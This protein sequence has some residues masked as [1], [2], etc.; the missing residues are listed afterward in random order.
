MNKYVLSIVML[1]LGI[2]L[3]GAGCSPT[4]P[5]GQ[6]ESNT[7]PNSGS[8]M[9]EEGD[10]VES[11]DDGEMMVKAD[12]VVEVSGKNFSFLP[13]VIT[14][15]KGQTVQINFTSEQGYHDWV[16]DEFDAATEQINAPGKNSVTFVADKA[17]EFEFYCSVGQHRQLG[18]V[19][20]LV[21][22]DDAMMESG[23]VMEKDGDSMMEN[24]SKG[25]VMSKEGSY[26]SYDVSKLSRAENG[27]V[28]LFFHA[29]WCPTCRSLDKKLN[30]ELSDFP[31]DLTVLKADYDTEKELRKKYAITSQHT[32]VQVDKDGNMIQKK[33]GGNRLSDITSWVK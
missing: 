5:E 21:V 30:E 27:D 14:V 8:A 9:M 11:K 3:V 20:K 24:D 1:G 19:G 10:S 23:D 15:E 31:A 16:V 29:N 6:M 17:G 12:V 2:V 26:E 28:V 32:L 33:I 25:E 18:M 13:N 22:A 4:Q 7:G